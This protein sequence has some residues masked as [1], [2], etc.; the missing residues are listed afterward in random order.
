MKFKII[1]IAVICSLAGSCSKNSDFLKEDPRG[2]LFSS[3][4]FNT[5]DQVET[6]VNYI[7]RDLSE[8]WSGDYERWGSLLAGADDVAGMFDGEFQQSEIFQV[9]AGNTD[10]LQGWQQIYQAIRTANGLIE[11]YT[12]VKNAS[13]AAMNRP[14]AEA[15]FARAYAYFWVVRLLNEAPLTLTTSVDFNIKKQKNIKI[16]N[17][18]I[19]DLKFAEEW[20]PASW[21]GIMNHKYVNGAGYTKGAAKAVLA[22]V[23]LSMAGYPIKDANSYALARDKAK[24]LIDNEATYG[25]GLVEKFADLWK[26]LPLKNKEMVF[27]FCYN[28]INQGNRRSPYAGQ[29]REY[30]GWDLYQAEINFYNSFPA[31]SRKDATF[32]TKFNF[33]DGTSKDWTAMPLKHPYYKKMWETEGFSWDKMWS[34]SD[35]QSNR[36]NQVIRYAEI[37][38]IYAEAQAKADGIPNALA[39]Q[40]VNRVRTRA[41][42]G[43]LSAGLD[44][45]AFSNAVVEE[46]A[47]EFAGLEF[48]SRWFDLVRLEKVE[49]A[50]AS[51]DTRELAIP[52]APTK[53][54]YFFPIP[55]TELLLLPSLSQTE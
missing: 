35:W 12:R 5:T 52:K 33:S 6:V 11:N 18:I 44:K 17:Q 16:Y 23:Y 32:V 55:E 7:Y 19:S 38:L 51:R 41:G 25:Y 39:Y 37:L 13:E 14:A 29:P 36:T 1:I 21:A 15:Y 45:T 8:V 53:A 43:S 31:G 42:L 27:G 24:E 50:A 4:Y 26:P 20:L 48:C 22:E 9:I 3:N 49:E 47:W 54:S 28:K 34:S 10:L 2:Q 46:R 40:C 30:G